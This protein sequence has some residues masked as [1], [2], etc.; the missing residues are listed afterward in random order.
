MR[1]A[2]VDPRPVPGSSVEALQIA[3]NVDA[4]AR[5]GN[6]IDLVTPQPP[7]DASIVDTLGRPWHAGVRAAYVPDYRLRWWAPSRS[8]RMFFRAAR[9]W[10]RSERPDAVWVRHLR[11]AEAILAMPDAPAVFF[12]THEVFAR[13][14]AEHPGASPRKVARLRALEQRVYAGSR[15]I[16]ALTRALADDVHA[17]YG[18]STPMLIAADGFDRVLA[19]RATAVPL[20]VE[21][22]ILYIGSLHPWKGVEIAIRAMRDV[23]H[24]SLVIVGGDEASVERLRALAD[25]EEVGER[26]RLVGAVAPCRR[27][28][29]IAAATLCVLPLSSARIA[30]RY[31]SPLKLFEYLALGKPVV[32]TDLASMREAVVHA[33]SAWLVEKAEPKGYAEAINRLL[34]DPA[35]RRTLAEEARLASRTR[36]WEARARSIRRFIAD[37]ALG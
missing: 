18:S 6:P 1:I 25:E 26:V 17:D 30:S 23:A 27:F 22:V 36:T 20:G 12:E 10:L 15:G 28:D 33:K 4:F 13:T 2:Y 34:A 37:N 16:I 7:S 21:P 5:I 29:W 31:T 8:N 24:G 19:D 9:R 3:Q 32:T 35:L 11:L 14:L